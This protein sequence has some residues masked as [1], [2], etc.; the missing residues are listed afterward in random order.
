M[1][2]KKMSKE[3]DRLLREALVGLLGL[4]L[5]SGATMDELRSLVS[6]CIHLVGSDSKLN[7]RGRVLD[8]HRLA[9]VLRAWHK[10]TRYL[11]SDGRP[12]P[13]PL[14]GKLG[15]S[16]L[17]STYYPEANIASAF[18][19]LKR[20][21]TNTE[22]IRETLGCLRRGTFRSPK[23]HKRHSTTYLKACRDFFKTVLQQHQ[24]PHEIQLT[25]RTVVQ[26]AQS[27]EVKSPCI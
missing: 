21:D 22:G 11:S 26:G 5:R 7:D 4:K 16:R 19:T 1:K 12:L 15:L 23:T 27:S 10:E 3:S 13:L 18:E 24:F 14:N 6:D 17:I 2:S 20:A 8:I 9:S 25:V